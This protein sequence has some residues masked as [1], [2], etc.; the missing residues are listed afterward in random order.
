MDIYSVCS[1]STRDILKI[2]DQLRDAAMEIPPHKM[3]FYRDVNIIIFL[4]NK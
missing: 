4:F 3:P 1:Y 2:V